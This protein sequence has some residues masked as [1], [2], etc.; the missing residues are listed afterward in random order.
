MK[1]QEVCEQFN[2]GSRMKVWRVLKSSHKERNLNLEESH[3]AASEK[4]KTG[5]PPAHIR[6]SM[7]KLDNDDFTFTPPWLTIVKKQVP[8]HMEEGKMDKTSEVDHPTTDERKDEE[9]Y[10]QRKLNKRKKRAVPST[11]TW[12]SPLNKGRRKRRNI[13]YKWLNGEERRALGTTDATKEKGRGEA[14]TTN[15]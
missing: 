10:H 1:G 7:K 9:E 4:K 8:V 6:K 12:H 11:C 15:E 13:N 5:D 2:K 3:K 14:P